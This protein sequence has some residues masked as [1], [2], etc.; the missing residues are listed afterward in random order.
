MPGQLGRYVFSTSADSQTLVATTTFSDTP[1]SV[2]FW[3]INTGTRSG[4]KL[5]SSFFNA[6]EPPKN[7]QYDVLGC[8]ATRSALVC[9]LSEIPEHQVDLVV[10]QRYQ[11]DDSLLSDQSVSAFISIHDIQTSHCYHYLFQGLEAYKLLLY[12][13]GIVVVDVQA[14]VL[15]RI[16]LNTATNTHVPR[17]WIKVSEENAL[18]RSQT[19]FPLFTLDRYSQTGRLMVSNDGLTLTYV[20][21]NDDHQSGGTSLHRWNTVTGVFLPTCHP[22]GL[23]GRANA[24][25]EGLSV[26]GS[27]LSILTGEYIH[28]TPGGNRERLEGDSNMAIS[29]DDRIFAYVT[30]DKMVIRDVQSNEDLLCHPF[31]AKPQDILIT[32]NRKT[33]VTVHHQMIRTWRIP[34]P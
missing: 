12:A 6:G 32:P 1:S 23:H 22:V 11:A 31:L 25:F 10:I 15:M 5:I 17:C 3:D 16:D 20:Q 14:K 18:Q 21:Y 27:R 34:P 13:T 7:P 33:L 30:G 2:T 24:S 26:D 19:Y 28:I 4:P 8:L 9:H 29:L